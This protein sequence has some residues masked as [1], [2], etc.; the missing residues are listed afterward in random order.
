MGIIR[1]SWFPG[2]TPLI[3]V[4]YGNPSHHLHFL[5]TQHEN[6]GHAIVESWAYGCPVLIS[7]NTP[8]RNLES[9]LV[10]WD[11]SLDEP[12][13]F[14]AAIYELLKMDTLTYNKWVASCFQFYRSFVVQKAHID[15]YRKELFA[16]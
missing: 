6:Y 8:W 11:I 5:P 3:L 7:D 14:E 2:I 9:E 10:G 12:K 15:L 1:T 4:Q 16:K 13:K